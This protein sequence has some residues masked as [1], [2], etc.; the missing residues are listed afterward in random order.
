MITPANPEN[1]KQLTYTAFSGYVNPTSYTFEGVEE[2]NYHR[3]STGRDL[4]LASFRVLHH[5]CQ[6]E[7]KPD[8]RF[9]RSVYRPVWAERNRVALPHHVELQ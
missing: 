8:F 6:P 5:R 9:H 4:F 1:G 3:R 2:G 7:R